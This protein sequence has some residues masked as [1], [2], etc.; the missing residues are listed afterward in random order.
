MII[1]LKSVEI[2]RNNSAVRYCNLVLY[3][4]LI[5]PSL[6][7]PS[8]KKLMQVNSEE[9]KGTTFVIQLPV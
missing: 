3:K 4:S 9:G 2:R 1:N 6:L 8:R 7:L 5:L